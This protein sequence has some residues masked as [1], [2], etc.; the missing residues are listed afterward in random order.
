LAKLDDG[1]SAAEAARLIGAEIEDSR[2]QSYGL[3]MMSWH[4]MMRGSH[5]RAV[6]IT[7]EAV[8]LASE[9]LGRATVQSYQGEV[10]SAAG[11]YA[12]GRQHLEESVAFFRQAHFGQVQAWSLARL[13]EGGVVPQAAPSSR[14]RARTD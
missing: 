10:C 6:E 5:D 4:A 3:A 9:P 13:S 11:A 2:L 14:P 7:R 8:A 12:E 1:S